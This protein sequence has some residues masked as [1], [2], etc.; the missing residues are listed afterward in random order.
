M[1]RGLDQRSLFTR[2]RVVALR[3]AVVARDDGSSGLWLQFEATDTATLEQIEL[4]IKTLTPIESL[5]TND[6]E[7]DTE[8]VVLADLIET[9]VPKVENSPGR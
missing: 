3:D 6:G 5:H 8:S 4:H 7:T 9:E 1:S 2:A